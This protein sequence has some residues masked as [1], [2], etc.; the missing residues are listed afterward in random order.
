MVITGA[1][2]LEGRVT[3]LEGQGDQGSGDRGFDYV[4][5][6]REVTQNCT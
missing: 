2:T 5:A 6:D 4:S 3:K 1:A